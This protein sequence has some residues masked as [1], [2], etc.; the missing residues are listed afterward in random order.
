MSPTAVGGGRFV[1]ALSVISLGALVQRWLILDEFLRRSPIAEEP[2]GDGWLY[3][4]WAGQI[5]AG[6]WL[7]ST[8]FLSLPL[9]PYLLGVARWF[10]AG[11]AGVA[12]LQVLISVITG[13]LVACIVRRRF[14]AVAGLLAA[15]LFFLLSEPAHASTR[16]LAST[17]QLLLVTLV[18]GY[19]AAL[20]AADR[21]AWGR[22][23]GTGALIGLLALAYPA[24][25]LLVPLYGLWLWGLGRWRIAGLGRAAVGAAAGAAVIAPA[26]LH[27]YAVAGELIPLTAH[28]GIT[29]RQG[30]G[31]GAGGVLAPVPGV[32]ADRLRMHE[33][34]QRV[35]EEA[36]GRRGSWAQIDRHF[37]REVLTWW[38][39]NPLRALKLELR[40]LHMFLLARRYDDIMP[41]ALEREFGLVDRMM[42]APLPTPWLLGAGAVGLLLILRRPRRFGPELL[43]LALPL[44]VTL[45]FFYSPRYRLPAVPLLCGLAAHALCNGRAAGVPRPLVLGAALAPGLLLFLS[46]E[47][48]LDSVEPMRRTFRPQLSIAWTQAGDRRADAGDSAGAEQRFRSALRVEPANAIALRKLGVLYATQGRCAEAIEPLRNALQHDAENAETLAWL[49]NALAETGQWKPATDCLRRLAK[50]APEQCEPAL[51]LI[52]MLAACP[53]ASLRDPAEALELAESVGDGPPDACD[54][55]EILAARAAAQAAAGQADQP[56]AT[57]PAAPRLLKLEPRWRS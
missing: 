46:D 2:W 39:E 29:L 19:W 35:Y 47:A 31:P 23:A 30:N 25:L 12:V 51:A 52:W 43:L 10:G 48:G 26:T 41:L 27:N 1:A 17:L 32:A 20:S 33:D 28:A 5:A 7:G 9:Y 14:G 3:W 50:K 36:H 4:Q 13:V 40:K 24:A 44:I 49:Y 53:D 38:S 45:V 55:T 8:P 56:A 16:V 34:A 11:L 57:A 21:P 54:R 22:I 37:R 42:L 15:A 18:W 6:R